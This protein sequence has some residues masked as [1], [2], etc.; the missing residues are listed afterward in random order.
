MSLPYIQSTMSSVRAGRESFI[1]RPFL[2][3]G[4]TD[5][6]V[7]NMACSQLEDDYDPEQLDLDDT[8]TS[9]A[10]AGVI[11]LPFAADSNAY[12]VGDTGHTAADGG[13][14]EFQRTFA[15]I[16][17]HTRIP[18]GSQNYSFPG[19]GEAVFYNQS[20]NITITSLK[21]LNELKANFTAVSVYRSVASGS[22]TWP[23]NTVTLTTDI[24]HTMV[25]G[26]YAFINISY[27]L[28]GDSSVHYVSA[29]F[30]V[31]STPSSSSITVD[32]GRIFTSEQ[33]MMI[34]SGGVR[35][36]SLDTRATASQ[37]SPTITESTYILPGVTP[38]FPTI[39]EV[40]IPP[41]FA[42]M[43]ITTGV[44]TT[45]AGAVTSP[46]KDEY[47]AM[48]SSKAQIIIEASVEVWMGNI[49][50]QTVKTIRAV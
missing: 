31:L 2:E 48:I 24:A 47:K 34:I 21:Q 4:D 14:I 18:T 11:A 38:G 8:M 5:T 25:A 20:G 45:M 30:N 50:K 15:N 23:S 33:S 6:K 17:K 46:T 36:S 32:L 28:S 39:N 1:S 37:N 35:S 27:L 3:D 49:V 13:M 16:P 19:W 22:Y 10:S 40:G 41:E 44:M 12:F 9:A 7:Y 29:G 43:D 26:D 42:V